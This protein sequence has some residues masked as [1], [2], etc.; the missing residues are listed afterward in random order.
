MEPEQLGTTIINRYVEH[1][2]NSPQG[3]RVA[4][5]LLDFGR[6]DTFNEPLNGV[7]ETITNIIGGASGIDFQ[8]LSEIQDVFFVNPAGDVRPVLDLRGLALD[9]RELAE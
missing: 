2:V 9:L 1:F 3:E 4:M 8:R 6:A 5:A 7:A